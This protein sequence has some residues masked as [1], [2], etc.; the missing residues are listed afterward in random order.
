MNEALKLAK[1]SYD[2][3]DIPIGAIIVF[4]DEIIGRGFN[5]KELLKDSS[6]HAE[7]IAMKE[8][9][10]FLNSYHLEDCTMY[11]TLEPCAMCAGAILNFRLKKIYIGAKNERFGCCGSKINLLNYNFNHTCECEFGIL[12][13]D[14]KNLISNFFIELRINKRG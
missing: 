9:S 10:K 7:L 3:G 12:E 2:N 1:I 11:V 6:A 14:C 4:N 13:D 8:A 5:K